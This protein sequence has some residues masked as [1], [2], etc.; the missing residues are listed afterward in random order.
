MTQGIS[1]SLRVQY[2]PGYQWLRYDQ[3]YQRQSEG[4]V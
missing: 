3:G 2:D 4:A 1:D